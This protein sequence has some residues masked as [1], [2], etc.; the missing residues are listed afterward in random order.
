MQ[1]RKVQDEHKIQSSFI[2]I[3]FRKQQ[4]NWMYMV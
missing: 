4:I 1:K 2:G 3:S